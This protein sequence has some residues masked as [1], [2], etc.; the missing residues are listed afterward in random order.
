LVAI[1]KGEV[2]GAPQPAVA[3]DAAETAEAGADA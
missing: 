1:A 3:A 2:T